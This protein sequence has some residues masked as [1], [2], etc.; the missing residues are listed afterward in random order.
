MIAC[1]KPYTLQGGVR[2]QRA[3]RALLGGKAA[4]VDGAAEELIYQG[5]LTKTPAG[6]AW[7]YDVTENGAKHLAD[8]A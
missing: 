7:R 2:G 1:W 4:F 5:L 6:K 8:V 3:L